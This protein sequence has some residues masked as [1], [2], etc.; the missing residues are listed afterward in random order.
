ML[1]LSNTVYRLVVIGAYARMASEGGIYSLV[2]IWLAFRMSIPWM[3]RVG[4]VAVKVCLKLP[5]S[6]GLILQDLACLFLWVWVQ[7]KSGLRHGQS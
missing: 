3:L 6:A 4:K 2:C 5:F 1:E 7:D